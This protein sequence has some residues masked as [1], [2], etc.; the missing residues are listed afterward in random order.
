MAVTT[1]EELRKQLAPF[2]GHELVI[3]TSNG[4]SYAIKEIVLSDVS[5]DV[6]LV[7]EDNTAAADD[8]SDEAYQVTEE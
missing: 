6:N 1:V 4:F 2:E 5:G 8:D 7:I 3:A